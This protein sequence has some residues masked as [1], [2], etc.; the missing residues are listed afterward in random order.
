MLYL[1]KRLLVP[2][3]HSSISSLTRSCIDIAYMQAYLLAYHR[4]LNPSQNL[5]LLSFAQLCRIR[6]LVPHSCQG[7]ASNVRLPTF[8]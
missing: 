3:Q 5:L 7:N 8:G 1:G 2:Y 6:K 4:V